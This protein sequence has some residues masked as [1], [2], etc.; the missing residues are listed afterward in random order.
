MKR[1]FLNTL[2][3][4][5]VA[6]F[7]L[8]SSASSLFGQTYTWT[9]TTDSDWNTSTNWSPNGVPD[10]LS[11][12][13]I[14]VSSGG[15]VLAADSK[16]GLFQLDSGTVDLAGYTL[17]VH[18]SIKIYGGDITAGKIISDQ[19]SYWGDKTEIH[20]AILDC[21]FDIRTPQAEALRSVFNDTLKVDQWAGWTKNW[22]ENIF[23]EH[24][25]L[26]QNGK[27]IRLGGVNGPDTLNSTFLLEMESAVTNWY[28]SG[29]QGVYY[30]GDIILRNRSSSRWMRNLGNVEVD[31]N[32]TVGTSSTGG[33]H[34]GETGYPI[35]IGAGY[36]L[37]VDTMGFDEGILY[38]YDLTQLGTAES[39]LSTLESTVKLSNCKFGGKL[40]TSE[41]ESTELLAGNEFGEVDLGNVTVWKGGVFNGKADITATGTTKN[42]VFHDS[43]NITVSNSLGMGYGGSDTAWAPVS[44]ITIG[45]GGVNIAG[46]SSNYFAD[47]VTLTNS[48]TSSGVVYASWPGVT[49]TYNKDVIINQTGGLRTRFYGSG[50]TINGTIRT[51]SIGIT[52]GDLYIED[53]VQT[54]SDSILLRNVDD[55]SVVLLDDLDINGHLLLEGGTPIMANTTFGG[56]VTLKCNSIPPY[57]CNFYGDCYFTKLGATNNLTHS[58][59]Y[60]GNLYVTNESNTNYLY[61]GAGSWK[62]TV[63]GDLT[64]VNNGDADLWFAS[65]AVI[66]VG[67]DI[68][69]DGTKEVKLG[70]VATNDWVKLNG[71]GNQTITIGDSID[72]QFYRIL[73]DKPNGNVIVEDSLVISHELD[74][75]RGSI[76][77]LED[78]MITFQDGAWVDGMTDSTYVDGPVKKVGNDAF[79]FPTG[80]AGTYRPIT[81]TAPSSTSTEYTVDFVHMN[82]NFMFGEELEDTSLKY[83]TPLDHWALESN[84]G[85][86]D[87]S[88][89][90]GW[91]DQDPYNNF[92]ISETRVAG[93]SSTGWEDLGGISHSGTTDAGTVKTAAVVDASDISGFALGAISDTIV[94]RGLSISNVTINKTFVTDSTLGSFD[95]DIVGG[96]DPVLVMVDSLVFPSIDSVKAFLD[97]ETNLPYAFIDTVS[98]DSLTDRLTGREHV[99]LASTLYDVKIFDANRDTLEIQIPVEYKSGNLDSNSV[100]VNGTTITKTGSDGWGTGFY[101]TKEA[102]DTLS[103]GS[104]SFHVGSTDKRLAAGFIEPD[105]TA[106]NTYQDFAAA[107]LLDADEVDVWMDDSLYQTSTTVVQSDK[108]E[109]RRENGNMVFLKNGTVVKSLSEGVPKMQRPMVAIDKV[110][111]FITDFVVSGPSEGRTQVVSTDCESNSGLIRVNVP[112]ANSYNYALYRSG[113]LQSDQPTFL[114]NSIMAYAFTYSDL[115]SGHYEIVRTNTNAPTITYEFYVGAD[116][117]WQ[118]TNGVSIQGNSANSV[119]GQTSFT[120]AS[121]NAYAVS[122]NFIPSTD[123]GWAS[124]KL[125]GTSTGPWYQYN[126]YEVYV[127]GLTSFEVANTP[128]DYE[129]AFIFLR[130]PNQVGFNTLMYHDNG[131]V[132]L[133]ADYSAGGTEFRIEKEVT[134]GTDVRFKFYKGSTLLHSTVA[135]E[136]LNKYH[137]AFSSA[138]DFSSIHEVKLSF[139]CTAEIDIS[140]CE[141]DE[142]RNWIESFGYDDNGGLIAHS[143]GYYDDFGKPT[144]AQT[145]LFEEDDVLASET[146]YDQFGRGVLSTLAAP[147]NQTQI[148][149][150]TD[151]ITN[152]NGDHYSYED[153]NI[154]NYTSDPQSISEGEV[155]FPAPVGN[156]V[157]HGLGWYYSNDNSDEA[158]VPASGY[159]YTRVEY[160][161]RN[162][163][164]VRRSVMAGEELEMGSGHEQVLNVM[165]ITD[166]EL[167][168]YLAI[169]QHFTDNDVST[170]A[171][172]GLK[173]ISTDPNNVESLTY[174]DKS[175]NLLATCSDWRYTSAGYHIVSSS[176]GFEV[177]QD[178]DDD[179]GFSKFNV[180]G[181][182]NISIKSLT[183]DTIIYEGPKSNVTAS[184]FSSSNDYRI[185]SSSDFTLDYD[186]YD[187]NDTTS[188]LFEAENKSELGSSGGF[189]DMHLP[190]SSAASLEFSYPEQNIEIIDLKTGDSVYV[191]KIEDLP[192]LDGGVYRMK[193]DSL[194]I[195]RIP[196]DS[197]AD[198]Y[199]E[200]SEDFSI[201]YMDTL[202]YQG[203][204]KTWVNGLPEHTDSLT[205]ELRSGSK[206]FVEYEDLDLNYVE[207]EFTNVLFNLW[208][209]YLQRD[210]DCAYYYYDN[211]DNLV[212][213]VPPLGVTPPITTLPLIYS[214][215]EYNSNGWV[216]KNTHPDEGSSEFVYDEEGK[217]RF[218]QNALQYADVTG[219]P[220][221][222]E[223]ERRFNYIEYDEKGRTTET[224]E[225]DPTLVTGT[226]VFF[227]AQYD[228]TASHPSG[229]VSVHDVI[230]ESETLDTDGRL[231][232]SYV[233]YDRADGGF[234][235]ETGLTTYEQTNMIGRVTKT[236]NDNS[237]SWYSYDERGRLVWL[238]RKI[239]DMEAG[240]N[241]DGVF[242]MDYEYDHRGQVTRIIFNKDESTEVFNHWMTYDDDGR[243][244]RVEAGRTETGDKEEIAAYDYY[245]HGPLKRVVLGNNLQGVDYVYTINGWLKSV[246]NPELGDRDPGGDDGTAGVA[247]E[248]LFGMTLDYFLGDYVREGTDIQTYDWGGTIPPATD[249]LPKNLYNGNIKAQRW[250]HET[251]GT[252]FELDDEQLFYGYQYDKANQLRSSRLAKV[253]GIGD[254]NY[255]PLNPPGTTTGYIGPTLSLVNDYKVE[256]HDYDPNGNILE[257]TRS[258]NSTTGLNMD[259]LTYS[260]EANTNKL[261]RVEDAVTGAPYTTDLTSGQGTNNYEYNELGQ[262]IANEDELQYY[263]YN[264]SGLITGVYSDNQFT[265]PIAKYEYDDLGF[266]VKKTTFQSSSPFNEVEDTW[267]IRDN[268]GNLIGV[269]GN[270]YTNLVPDPSSQEEL[271][272]SAYGRVGVWDVDGD[273]IFELS[274]HLGNVRSTFKDNSG[275]DRASVMD[276]YPFGWTQ[277]GRLSIGSFDYRYGYQGQ[278]AEQDDE[279]GLASFELRS[280]D[281]R[282]CRWSTFDPARQY[283]SPY[284]SMGNNPI[285]GL[286]PDGAYAT[287]FGAWLNM[288]LFGGDRIG[289][290][291]NGWYVDYSFYTSE[292]V[293]VGSRYEGPKFYWNSSLRFDYGLQFGGDIDALGG[294][295]GLFA[296]YETRPIGEIEI[297]YKHDRGFF[298]DGYDK[299]LDGPPTSDQ[300]H[301]SVD[302]GL[303]IV[304]AE[305]TYYPAGRKDGFVGPMKSNSLNILGR[306]DLEYNFN[307][308]GNLTSR[309]RS[310]GV[311]LKAGA[312]I[313]IKGRLFDIGVIHEY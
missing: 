58:N 177:L 142:D 38:L 290:D 83:I 296:E 29:S 219:S 63:M 285:S 20:D 165:P 282:I 191:G 186:I 198:L 78:G 291:D 182:G 269:Y 120:T 164:R 200:C 32:I 90:I 220:Q 303:V 183:Q 96:F 209:E 123:N 170:L 41:T 12:V 124:F 301:T 149:Y 127:A 278:F 70:A 79:T 266:R 76:V 172:E 74:F 261:T 174:Y 28:L 43:T 310:V 210:Y 6:L 312:G 184:L 280:I 246:N 279:T 313:G 248:D 286:D 270:P 206:C 62:D 178:L 258:G 37:A 283:H 187:T 179:E 211:A 50:C 132:N 143:K 8:V 11:T 66:P 129:A 75:D 106:H 98:G 82:P 201:F 152:E 13:I 133:N 60:H 94:P 85:A 304:G 190:D 295:I 47:N 108:L 239:E 192:Q 151:F 197:V 250:K 135:S 59:T 156:S 158:Y 25:H 35:T 39:D 141:E 241:D 10:S 168:H 134:T 276:Y 232:R 257:L 222:P 46:N 42:N 212:A 298:L 49:T 97:L 167:W 23:N 121:W 54:G 68:H 215:Y 19:Q 229:D 207:I 131:V 100:T 173:H 155:D 233:T 147:I 217:L 114:F 294:E 265:E 148:C 249:L 56:G 260:Y 274:D 104:I 64:L 117:D 308:N 205:Y 236:W 299:G 53:I 31:G 214:T 199:I 57:G 45:V 84:S 309:T 256:I 136:D 88:W 95:L 137:F 166:N 230:D 169:G 77:C 118:Q 253:S 144:Q 122:E 234:G 180:Y 176:S 1:I 277:P 52:D 87:V 9:G 271:N 130:S 243:L 238:V 259:D 80:E 15:P 110:G 140:V 289:K 231:E 235:T 193:G 181:S 202:V 311:G 288:F 157:D 264:A 126:G 150:K 18:K 17:N 251:V 14:G 292:E 139:G 111:G 36:G 101:S 71:S 67:G 92:Q 224:G 297:G 195:Y 81:M 65:S 119:M 226:S 213:T 27:D 245:L 72:H 55:A 109:I 51:G 300:F 2:S 30:G 305:N 255:D 284:L 21:S 146:V 5:S 189:L 208:Y 103:D 93:W 306:G 91:H 161:D 242:T 203:G 194:Y 262:M 160:D 40:I 252:G 163:D 105:S 73:I 273:R 44:I 293:I 69:I 48:S 154:A 102:L 221:Y 307:R 218:S 204:T 196:A 7:L 185:S 113:V 145:R 225:Y 254:Q 116:P 281:T 112:F 107:F 223:T 125:P 86:S 16:V 228:I 247:P 268:G 4:G 244:I 128:L 267:Y 188:V 22:G 287:K 115:E 272:L 26:I 275:L 216:L 24:V 89:T 99:E 153:F 175:G 237:A 159:P 302:V 227:E 34:L 171:Y 138:T 61:M 33:F 240:I 263:T 3:I 162:P